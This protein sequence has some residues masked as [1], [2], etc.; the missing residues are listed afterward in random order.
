MLFRIE[1]VSGFDPKLRKYDV[2]EYTASLMVD[3]AQID[4][5]IA[6]KIREEVN[7][8]ES[9]ELFSYSKSLATCIL[10]YN[11]F[12]DNELHICDINNRIDYIK[13]VS[14]KG[15]ERCKSYSLQDRV[16]GGRLFNRSGRIQLLNFIIDVSD[17]DLVDEY[18]RYYTSAGK[19]ILASPEKD[20]E[21]VERIS[22][23]LCS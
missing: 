6:S 13:Y 12:T 9:R 7:G 5:H 1:D 22:C 17:N 3:K 11:R 18:L 20:S 23:I 16:S 14:S 19:K 8:S 4:K 10:K 21:V 2:D 15:N